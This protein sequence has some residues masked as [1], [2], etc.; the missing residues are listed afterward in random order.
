MIKILIKRGTATQWSASTTPLASGE[1]GLDTTNNILKAGNGTDLWATLNQ[2][3]LTSSQVD[4]LARDAIG[5]ALV[6]GSGISVNVNDAADSITVSIDNTIATKSYTDTAISNLI[7]SAPATLDTLN[8]LATALGNDANFATTVTNSLA[9]KVSKSGGDIITPSTA[10]TIGLIIKGAAS[11]TANLTEWKDSAGNV[12]VSIDA[13]GQQTW[14]NSSGTTMA[15]TSM[16]GEFAIKSNLY[17]ADAGNFGARLNILTNVTTV[18]G[19]VIRGAASQTADLQ[20]WQNS[21]GSV[22]SKVDSTGFFSMG[23][24]TSPGGILGITASLA[25]YRPLVIKAAASQTANLTEWQDSSG[26]ILALINN[27]G[28]IA[29][30]GRLT[31]GSSSVSTDARMVLLNTGT[32]SSV[33]QIIRGMASQ[34]GDLLQWQRSDGT[35]DLKVTNFGALISGGGTTIASNPTINAYGAAMKIAS[36]ISNYPMLILQA[37]ASQTANLQEWQLNNGFQALRVLSN[38]SILLGNT[39]VDSNN[40]LSFIKAGGATGGNAGIRFGNDVDGS[41]QQ[42]LTINTTNANL[43]LEHKNT[44]GAFIIQGATSQTADLLKWQNSAG[45]TLGSITANGYFSG[46]SL[47]LANYGTLSTIN[48][49]ANEVPVYVVGAASQTAD[50]QQWVD[51]GLN[52]IAK[53][54]ANGNFKGGLTYEINIQTGTSYT[55]ALSDSKSVVLL[56]NENNITAY[57]PTNSIAFP[58][59]SSI[60]VVQSGLGQV[61]IQALTPATTSILSN[62][63]TAATPRLRGYGSSVTLIKVTAEQ[64]F[65]VGDIY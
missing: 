34:T 22:I 10:S 27:S 6:G 20:Q 1:L 53:I 15:Y 42:T 58:I 16:Y 52:T 61:T 7:N 5:S 40:Y 64:W 43:L 28:Q 63:V 44:T 39:N 24:S 57:I 49:V 2:I 37:A 46:Q 12:L 59:G 21:T 30:Y 14:K 50:L 35:V 32:T 18:I 45:T 8:E 31:V 33:L 11:Q 48:L 9:G 3:S 41:N 65:A 17:L 54:D 38:G 19:A 23:A 13:N 55:F 25:T 56:N 4:E 47:E 29:T 26:S 36:G 62:A 51:S 60:T